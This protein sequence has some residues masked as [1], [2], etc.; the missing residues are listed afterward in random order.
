MSIHASAVRIHTHG[1][2]AV[3]LRLEA[4]EVGDP[5]PGQVRLVMRLAPINPA[6]LNVIEGTYGRLPTLPATVGNEGLGEVVAVGAGVAWPLGTL[7]RPR[8]GLGTWCAAAIA[9]VAR[10]TRLP[11]GLPDDQAAQLGVNPA[12]AWAVLHEFGPLH[13]GAWV[14]CNAPA[15]GVGRSLAAL[16]AAR[17]LRL[18]CLVRRE[19]EAPPGTLAVPEGREAVKVLK[20]LGARLA[21]NQVGGDSAV[22]LAK[23]LA[24]QGALVTIGA[25]ARQPLSLPNGAVIFNE[26]RCCGFWVSRWYERAEPATVE[27]M[28]DELGGLMRDGRL[29]LPVAA[30]YPLT[31]VQEAVIHARQSGRGGKVLLD[32]PAAG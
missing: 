13:S 4:V 31:Q 3:V 2:P 8:D 14:L 27:A 16:C 15:S 12:T 22:S 7:V 21:L 18:A 9:D 6:D 26:L 17:G 32:C 25:L 10:C 23:A 5:G 28:M 29:H 1:D 19:G 24:P 11:A 30:T 20:A